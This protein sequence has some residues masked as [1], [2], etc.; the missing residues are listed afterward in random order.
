MRHHVCDSD[1]GP[2]T[3]SDTVR[4]RTPH[5]LHILGVGETSKFVQLLPK[6]KQS[7][8]HHCA[9]LGFRLF[10]TKIVAFG[11]FSEFFE[12]SINLSRADLRFQCCPG[13]FSSRNSFFV[14]T[15]S[16]FTLAP[17]STALSFSRSSIF[18]NFQLVIFPLQAFSGLLV[19]L[20]L[21][22]QHIWSVD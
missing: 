8:Q 19:F 18:S 12:C 6:L 14:R 15:L 1:V 13:P 22:F 7:S 20:W 2:G 4:P 16:A 17:T 11:L 10:G 3:I 21:D 9:S 5:Y